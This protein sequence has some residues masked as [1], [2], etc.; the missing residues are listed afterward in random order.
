MRGKAE[1][2]S[3][4]TPRLFDCAHPFRTRATSCCPRQA[5]LSE[6]D[7]G[8]TTGAETTTNRAPGTN[9]PTDC[10]ILLRLA[11]HGCT[12]VWGVGSVQSCSCSLLPPAVVPACV[13]CCFCAPTVLYVQIVAEVAGETVTIESMP[14]DL[15]GD[16]KRKVQRQRAAVYG[17]MLQPPPPIPPALRPV[18]CSPAQQLTEADTPLAP[19]LLLACC[20][21]R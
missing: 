3:D 21:S 6:T 10:T 16:V 11:H 12:R 1:R 15:V 20:R 18:R 17:P 8:L 9:T 2:W 4:G 14:S 19:F 13:T 5:E 7:A